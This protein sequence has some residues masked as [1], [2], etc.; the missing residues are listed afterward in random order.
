MSE[1]A[2]LLTQAWRSG[3]YLGSAVCYCISYQRL[4]KY[5]PEHRILR[6]SYYIK[7]CFIVLEASLAMA[8]VSLMDSAW[9]NV[10]AVIEWSEFGCL[11]SHGVRI[12]RHADLLLAAIAFLFSL[13][14]LSFAIDFLHVSRDYHVSMQDVSLL[15]VPASPKRSVSSQGDNQL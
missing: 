12:R 7:L 6:L 10:A 3:G 2:V 4:S 13:Y 15:E 1:S 11:F 8:F 14:V 5:Y 9:R